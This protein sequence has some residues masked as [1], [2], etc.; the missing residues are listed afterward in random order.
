MKNVK[1][2]NLVAMVLDQ[3]RT[4]REVVGTEVVLTHGGKDF[5]VSGVDLA[6]ETITIKEVLPE[7]SVETPVE[8]TLSSKNAHV[9]HYRRNPNERPIVKAVIKNDN[10]KK[11]LVVGDEVEIEVFLG[12][13]DVQQ[14]VACTKGKVILTVKDNNDNLILKS[15]DV[16]DDTFSDVEVYTDE[17]YPDGE[18]LSIPVD[19]KIES[20]RVNDE[21]GETLVLVTNRID[22]SYVDEN[23]KPVAAEG[24]DQY[25]LQV[26][27]D[28]SVRFLAAGGSYDYIFSSIEVVKFG[29]RQLLITR[30]EEGYEYND[31]V[32]GS[33]A[34]TLEKPVI[35]INDYDV[36][37]SGWYDEDG[38]TSPIGV[39][40]VDSVDAKVYFGG[41][42]NDRPVITIVDIDSITISNRHGNVVVTDAKIVRVLANYNYFDGVYSHT[43]ENGDT[44]VE[45]YFS[46]EKFEEKML[47]VKETDR[48]TL[49]ELVDLA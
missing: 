30:C 27:S 19:A 45:W 8:I 17:T 32:D 4:G 16:Q 40:A 18:G 9:A 49:M 39:F 6:N 15:Y 11:S 38:S 33:I 31:V 42:P 36:V 7:D 1:N 37:R 46:N 23:G 35:L 34:V 26:S 12:T 41:T 13:L 28:G 5:V 14:I 3:K 25:L 24:V 22:K 29:S 10:G 44:V 2:N 48:G 47:S 20:V 21:T 43:D